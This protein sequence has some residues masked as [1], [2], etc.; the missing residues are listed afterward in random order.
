[1]CPGRNVCWNNDDCVV[2][3]VDINDEGVVMSAE[4]K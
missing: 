1:M 2:M 3:S 4:I